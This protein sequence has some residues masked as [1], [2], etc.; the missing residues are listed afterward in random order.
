MG[1]DG[2]LKFNTEIDEKGFNSGIT[3]LGGLA[4]SGIKV[5]AASVAGVETA[6]GTITKASLNSVASLEQNIGG[7]ETLFK[8]SAQTVIDN[9][10]NAYMTAGMS[11][12]KY[13]ENVTSFSASLL[14]GLGGDTAEAARIAQMAMVDMSDNANKF[15][16]NIEDIQNAYQGFAKQNYTMLDNLKLGYGGTQSEMIRLIND[17]GILNEQI[18]N[19]DNVTFDQM[20]QAIHKIQENMGIAGTTSAEALT[21]IEG[22]VNAA[23]SA[24]DNFLNGSGS[25]E[26]LAESVITAGKNITN[27]LLQIVPRLA[28]EFP[29]VGSLLIDSLSESLNSGKLNELMSVGGQVVSNL[30]MGV[31]QAIPGIIT[32][33]SQIIVSFTEN[34]SSLIPQLL[35]YGSQI[36]SSIV[37]GMVKILPSI[38]GFG[39]QLAS[40]LYTI[41][42][43]QGPI[44]LQKGYEILENL[45]SGFV[46]AIPEMLPKI[47]DFIQGVGEKLA[48][49]APILI[50]K[51]FEL[52]SQLVEGIVSAIPILIARVP[53]IIS[54]FANII[55]DNFP[56]ILLKGAELIGQ[57]ILGILQ[58]IPTL[59]ENIPKIVQAIVDVIQ[60]FQWLNLG[61][62]IVKGFCDGIK[63][64]IGLAKK[65]GKNILDAVKNAVLNLPSTLANIGQNAMSGFGNAIS[66][67]VGFIKSAA[68]N[69][70]STIVS[71]ISSIPGKMFSIGGNIIRGLWNGISDMT[72]WIIEKIGGFADSV[73][74]SICDFFG[75][76]SPSRVMRDEVGKYLAQGIG[77]GFEKNIPYE[78][79]ERASSKVVSKLRIATDGI[80]ASTSHN[81]SGISYSRAIDRNSSED[82]YR[83]IDKLAKLVERPININTL[84]DGK[85][86]AKTTAIPMSEEIEKNNNFKKI[87]KGESI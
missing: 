14:Q 76:K 78:D 87:L 32:A 48:E 31:I 73:V 81:T 64:M 11:A 19:L 52:L 58:A 54:T 57:L 86:V 65:H 13:M 77:V 23:K 82:I 84:I 40:Q 9:A 66:S 59:V 67:A 30:A 21:T 62:S 85:V 35:S 55:N 42:T 63:S 44:F 26:Q 4:K 24:F 17:S 53:E 61:Q 16:S 12:N 1:Y 8:D 51:G 74:T 47:L 2:S 3:K 70:V 60:A 69:I 34:L 25:P 68:S 20:I 36:I 56:I 28:E 29:K 39:V 38:G 71:T 46:K 72:G 80:T 41:L 33:A 50:Q 83:A 79:M 6:F 37:E 7:V 49:A 10:N 15:G 5:L 27:N 75:I 45:I 18:E 22:S 43:E